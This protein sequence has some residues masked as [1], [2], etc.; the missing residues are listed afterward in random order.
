LANPH[1]GVSLCLRELDKADELQDL[2]PQLEFHVELRVYF[3]FFL[4]EGISY[5][6]LS[7]SLQFSIAIYEK[8]SSCFQILLALFCFAGLGSDVSS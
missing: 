7:S 3:L 5:V 2:H 4:D 1:D 8:S 6:I